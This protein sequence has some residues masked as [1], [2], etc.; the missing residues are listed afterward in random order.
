MFV[1]L[2]YITCM[3]GYTLPYTCKLSPLTGSAGSP[4]HI[5]WSTMLKFVFLANHDGP[6][7]PTG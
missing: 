6:T 3:E 7:T 4:I 2:V 1:L 5:L